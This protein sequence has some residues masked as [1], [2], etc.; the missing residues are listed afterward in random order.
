[1]KIKVICINLEKSNDRRQH[2]LNIADKITLPFE[3]FKAYDFNN[4]QLVEPTISVV[5]PGPDS[6]YIIKGK[7]INLKQIHYQD[8]FTG[9]HHNPKRYLE[10]QVE[11]FGRKHYLE[12]HGIPYAHPIKVIDFDNDHCKKWINYKGVTEFYVDISNFRKYIAKSEIACALSHYN[13][14]KKLAYD[15]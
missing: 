10:D 3:F 1:M 4:L 15:D 8:E 12:Y 9:L 2:M 5:D 6:D 11:H 7:N 14:L 13:V